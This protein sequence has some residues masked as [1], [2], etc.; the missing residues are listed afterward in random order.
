M[1][2]LFIFLLLANAAVFGYAYYERHNSEAQAASDRYKPV[3][4]EQVRVLTTQQISKLGPAKVAQL[5][6]ACAE[7][8]PLSEADRARAIKLLEPLGLARTLSTRRVDVPAEHWVY[9]PPKPNKNAADRAL[10]DL[11]RLNVKD[12]ALIQDP[13]QWN[14]AI[15]LGV[16][17]NKDG[18]DAR[19]AEVKKLGV[20][21]AAY[22]TRAQTVAMTNLVLRE[23]AQSTI[24]QLETLRAQIAG[25]TVATGACPEAR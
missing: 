24:T 21:T 17:R 20:K 1:K 14:F 25:T 19:L 23:P 11:K 13:G 4:A 9:I 6:L 5:T 16:F 18:A 22:A 12:V 10:A 8:G 7:W 3:N 2:K 15:S